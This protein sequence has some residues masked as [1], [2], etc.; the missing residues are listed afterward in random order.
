MQDLVGIG[1][2]LRAKVGCAP[3]C[4]ALQPYGSMEPGLPLQVSKMGEKACTVCDK[5]MKVKQIPPQCLPHCPREVDSGVYDP[6]LCCAHAD[7]RCHLVMSQVNAKSAKWQPTAAFCAHGYFVKGSM[8][9]E[10]KH[11]VDNNPLKC[12]APGCL[13]WIGRYT[14]AANLQVDTDQV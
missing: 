4:N 6:C 9:A 12:P 1:N 7:G 14:M 5:K 10:A 3:A 13:S 11:I 8:G 2:V